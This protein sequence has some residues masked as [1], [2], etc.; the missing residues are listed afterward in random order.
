MMTEGQDEFRVNT[1][2]MEQRVFSRRTEALEQ[3]RQ[4]VARGEW[5][6]V[7]EG[8]VGV[9]SVTKIADFPGL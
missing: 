2:G 6:E 7:W 8:T 4:C 5:C 3:F 9:N 1:K